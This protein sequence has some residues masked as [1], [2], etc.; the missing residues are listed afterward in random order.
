MR[1]GVV[2]VEQ[3]EFVELRNLGHTRRQRQIVGRIFEQRIARDFNLVIMNVRLGP[4][5]TNGLRV[6]DEV[7]FMTAAS[8][9]KPQFSGDN[10]TAAVGRI[11]RNANLH[12]SPSAR[13]TISLLD[14]RERPGMQGGARALRSLFA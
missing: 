8:K 10:S 3:I 14:S 13:S 7:N 4:G 11:T 1:N 12:E 2:D 6:G 5:Q 9:L